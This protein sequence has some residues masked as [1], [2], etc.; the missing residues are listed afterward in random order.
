LQNRIRNV[1][2]EVGGADGDRERELRSELE[3]LQEQLDDVEDFGE[4]LD[5]L[6]D[7][8]FEPDFEAGIWENIQKV[9]EYDLLQTEL[10]KL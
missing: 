3:E 9:D 6:I 4:R 1:E 7:D 8:G 2:T 5:A 10:D